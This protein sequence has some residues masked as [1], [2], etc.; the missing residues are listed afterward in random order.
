[1]DWG[2]IW[3]GVTE[4][5]SETWDVVYDVA[6]EAL[7]KSIQDVKESGTNVNT[8]RENEPVKGKNADGTPIVVQTAVPTQGSTPQY[9]QG[10]DN[11]VIIVG[12]ALLVVVLGFLLKGKG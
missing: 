9:I 6:G 7:A 4:A 5:V 11:T 10:V 12:G 1:M 3:G 8:L 2:A